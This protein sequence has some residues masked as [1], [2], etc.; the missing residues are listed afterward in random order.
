M[1]LTKEEEKVYDGEYGW[2]NQVAMKILVRLGD[3]FAATKLI[4]IKSA[5]ISGVSYKTLGVYFATC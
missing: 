2:A 5:R 1:H 4:P 3:L